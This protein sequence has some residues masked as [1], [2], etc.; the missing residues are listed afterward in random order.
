L[1]AGAAST[2]ER[3]APGDGPPPPRRL[4]TSRRSGPA[5]SEGVLRDAREG[6]ACSRRPNEDLPGPAAVVAGVRPCRR[7][8]P[9]CSRE[10]AGPARAEDQ[11]E[12]EDRKK[13][14][15]GR[16]RSARARRPHR[17]ARRAARSGRWVPQSPAPRSRRKGGTEG[18]IAFGGSSLVVAEPPGHTLVALNSVSENDLGGERSVAGSTRR[19]R[20]GSSPQI[21]QRS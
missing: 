18:R 19:S 10:S 20:P 1:P 5:C 8:R 14:G 9:R 13:P 11:P 2:G 17:P 3:S 21:H 6:A 15:A 16:E 7:S 12:G 4:G